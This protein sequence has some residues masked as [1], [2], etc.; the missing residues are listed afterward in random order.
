MNFRV[1]KGAPP[2]N[3]D[4]LERIFSRFSGQ[5]TVFLEREGGGELL[6]AHRITEDSCER[7][8]MGIAK[9]WLENAEMTP[10]LENAAVRFGVCATAPR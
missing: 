7:L 1:L 10:A 6:I 4:A 3:A 8:I 5:G 9:A 2:A